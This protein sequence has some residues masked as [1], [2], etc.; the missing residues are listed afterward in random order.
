MRKDPTARLRKSGNECL[1]AGRALSTAEL[2]AIGDCNRATVLARMRRAGVTPIRE[3]GGSAG[4][5]WS[6]ADSK[7]FCD[8]EI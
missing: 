5:F 1:Q 6:H 8:R 4:K 3:A 7:R 2:A